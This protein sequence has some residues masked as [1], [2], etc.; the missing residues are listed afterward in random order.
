MQFNQLVNQTIPKFLTEETYFMKFSRVICTLEEKSTIMKF[1]NK[2]I[3]QISLLY[4][5][6]DN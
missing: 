4:R 2:T 1:F 6:S 5:A 3:K